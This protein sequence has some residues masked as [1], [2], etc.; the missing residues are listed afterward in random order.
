MLQI[1][2][3]LASRRFDPKTLKL[4]REVHPSE[5]IR[6]LAASRSQE[7]KAMKTDWKEVKLQADW[8]N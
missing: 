2:Q 5:S 1:G 4:M 7:K 8:R 6:G 3:P